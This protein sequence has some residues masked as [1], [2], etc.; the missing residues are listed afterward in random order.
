[1][2]R[3]KIKEFPFDQNGNLMHYPEVVWWDYAGTRDAYGMPPRIGP[4]WIEVEPFTA[5]LEFDTYRRGRSAAYFIWK[6][7]EGATYPMFLKD[8]SELL[9]STSVIVNGAVHARWEIVKRGRNYGI[10]KVAE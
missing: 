1:M 8:L 3:G 2:S 10:R 6:D 5:T 4:V 7:C 9:S